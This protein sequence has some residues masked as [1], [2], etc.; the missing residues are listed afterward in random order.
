MGF[1]GYFNSVFMKEAE[2][3]LEELQ[4]DLDKLEARSRFFHVTRTSYYKNRK[5]ALEREIEYWGAVYAQAKFDKQ[6]E[7][8][9]LA[10]LKEK[11]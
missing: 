6:D 10:L 11:S 7:E 4:K 2:A 5:K 1:N 9:K 8:V 3:K